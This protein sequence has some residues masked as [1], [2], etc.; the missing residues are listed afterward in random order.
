[1]SARST[2]FSE[3]YAKTTVG[4]LGFC[5]REEL[6][7]PSADPQTKAAEET[8]SVRQVVDAWANGQA[9]DFAGLFTLAAAV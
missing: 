6:A 3:S 7:H 1:M 8:A 4:L 5:L 9:A 2:S